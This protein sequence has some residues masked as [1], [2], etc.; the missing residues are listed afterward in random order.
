M[1]LDVYSQIDGSL[2]AELDARCQDRCV[3]GESSWVSFNTNCSTTCATPSSSLEC[4]TYCATALT[5]GIALPIATPR[6][7]WV[8]IS[9]SLTSSPMQITCSG[10]KPSRSMS[11]DSAPHFELPGL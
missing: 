3:R 6:P 5:A 1:G 9:K 11:L 2:L 10:V 8:I 4:V 7:A